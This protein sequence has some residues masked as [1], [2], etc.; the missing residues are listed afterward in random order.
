MNGH[1]WGHVNDPPR[2]IIPALEPERSIGALYDH[3]FGRLAARAALDHV[4]FK[5]DE[6]SHEW[7]GSS[8]LKFT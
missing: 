3:I 6:A 4:N 5:E 2:G 8:S 7:E 1:R